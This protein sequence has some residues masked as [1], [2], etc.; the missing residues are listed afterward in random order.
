[1]NELFGTGAVSP[2]RYFGVVALLLGVLFAMLNPE[3]TTDRGVIVALVQWMAQVVIPM[4][5][6]IMSHRVLH[7]HR[8]FDRLHPWLKL[9]I[10]GAVASLL[11]S[12]LA[13]GIDHALEVDGRAMTWAGWLEEW[14][15]VTLPVTFAWVAINMPF[16]LGYRWERASSALAFPV[17]IEPEVNQP[18][19]AGPP[20][21]VA[22][23]YFESLIPSERRG[24]VISLKADLHY[25][26]VSTTKGRTMIL[27]AIGDAIGEL[28]ASS[29]IQTHRSYWVSLHHCRGLERKGRNARLKM[30][31]GSTIPVSRSRLNDVKR[32]LK[33][34]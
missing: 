1:M 10:S 7:L 11:F 32:A 34:D 2:R 28:P 19:P 8:R 27:Y 25:M 5:L 26:T 30:S 3:G 14:G 9:T 31:D 16:V 15:A 22:P 12:P 6:A 33:L 17:R 18:M 20:A 23:P 21:T 4:G 24:D 13:Y 29:G